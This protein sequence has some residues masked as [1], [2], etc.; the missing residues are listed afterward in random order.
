MATETYPSARIIPVEFPG[1][2]CQPT[3]ADGYP[4]EQ[5][6]GKPVRFVAY[7]IGSEHR[8]PG[9]YLWEGKSHPPLCHEHAREM[10]TRCLTWRCRGAS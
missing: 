4:A 8:S 2:T 5:D 6:C 9:S 7:H 3:G 10:I 1:A